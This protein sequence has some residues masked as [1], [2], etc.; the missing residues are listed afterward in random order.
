MRSNY[1]EVLQELLES[2]RAQASKS[3]L[4]VRHD[5]EEKLHQV[6]G[7]IRQGRFEHARRLEEDRLTTLIKMH[8]LENDQTLDSLETLSSIMF[9]MEQ[10]DRGGKLLDTAIYARC[11]LQGQKHRKTLAGLASKVGQLHTVGKSVEAE[12]LGSKLVDYCKE[13]LKR[14]D[15]VMLR[16]MS[17]L[18]SIYTSQ[19]AL[20]KAEKLCLEVLEIRKETLQY[21][22]LD[23]VRSMI[24][25]S[26]IYIGQERWLN[27]KPL[28][29]SAFTI[30]RRE[31]GDDHPLTTKVANLLE[32]VYEKLDL[33]KEAETV[34]VLLL[35]SARKTHGEEHITVQNMLLLL[36]RTYIKIGA[37]KKSSEVLQKLLHMKGKQLPADHPEMLQL[38]SYQQ[39]LQEK[40]PEGEPPLS[41]VASSIYSPLT[42]LTRG[43][44]LVHIKKGSPESALHADLIHVS[45]DNPPPYEALSYMWGDKE[46]CGRLKLSGHEIDITFNLQAALFEL[47]SETHHRTL[48]IDA[49][50]INQGNIKERSEQVRQMREIY[51]KATRTIAWLGPA[52][53][54]SD[55]AMKFLAELEAHPLPYSVA[56]SKMRDGSGDAAFRGLRSLFKHRQYWR[57]VWIIQEIV[58][59]KEVALQCGKSAVSYETLERLSGI[60]IKALEMLGSHKNMQ[61]Y[62]PIV[63]DLM[64]SMPN[65][66][67][68]HSNIANQDD[69]LPQLLHAYR[70]SECTDPRDR[71]FA[72]LGLSN[73]SASGHPG[74]QIDYSRSISEVYRGAAQ[75]IIEETRGLDILCCVSEASVDPDTGNYRAR[76]PDLPS[77]APD[78]N[79]CRGVFVTLASAYPDAKASNNSRPQVKFSSDGNV[80]T[81]R[82]Y[83]LASIDSCSKR[84]EVTCRR[85][86][87]IIPILLSWRLQT[88]DRIS[89]LFHQGG[90]QEMIQFYRLIGSLQSYS[91]VREDATLWTP[92]QAAFSSQNSAEAYELSASE[93][94]YVWGAYQFCAG[95]R[96]FYF[97]E[98]RTG[99]TKIGLCPNDAKEG[100]LLCILLG[101][102]Y[103]IILHPQDN[104]Y[105]V[106]GEALVLEYIAGVALDGQLQSFAIR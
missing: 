86:R 17:N 3:S 88:A 103:P 48:W 51:V 19:Q 50:C 42:D 102:K 13:H 81:A 10:A 87:D 71:V 67:R 8:G 35:S 32:H 2:T 90:D 14:G 61:K 33:W 104:Y 80:M 4:V 9:N 101:C 69:S 21:G 58:C 18:A 89:P 36:T 45:L 63:M 84:F 49:L 95:R 15:V 26:G 77:W 57:R 43:I 46:N 65:I 1:N 66:H 27:A 73:L 92:W 72:L 37:W 44:R 16:A 79:T 53:T 74:L 96:V 64:G 70:V 12:L 7:F 100:D 25:L 99:Y 78:W 55:T 54:E 5:I 39:I 59:S 91:E 24:N 75:A 31:L 30:R 98:D 28:L 23:M 6:E 82:G 11:R 34:Q 40:F 83:A 76:Q 106:V 38:K 56:F 94:A 22:D 105:T 68:Q 47:R 41:K 93:K 62:G 85:V 20:D 60:W 52:T 29:E 97:R